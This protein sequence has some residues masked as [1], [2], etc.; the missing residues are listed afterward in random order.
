MTK[1]LVAGL[2]G[3]TGAG[4][5]SVAAILRAENLAVI[6]A[7]DVSR[8]VVIHNKALLMELTIN[9]GVTILNADGTLNRKRLG[10]IVFGDK[11]KLK[12]LNKIIFP[13]I[14][15]EIMRRID[16]LRG[17][18]ERLVILDAPT[19]FESGADKVCDMIAVVTAPLDERLNRIVIRDR[20]S[21]EEARARVRS[22]PEVEFYTE[23]ADYIIEND[24]SEGDLSSKT[25]GLV[26]FLKNKIAN[27]S[28]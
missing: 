19:L 7:D 24:G 5:S 23:R 2:T 15:T 1:I 21:D 9:F 13:F 20:L 11:E 16:D 17:I 22:Q 27:E 28:V 8:Y 25:L 26:R 12:K 4:K 10:N 14:I 6:D 3:Q 18:G